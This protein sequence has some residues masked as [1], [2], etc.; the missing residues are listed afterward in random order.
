LADL[1]CT[2]ISVPWTFWGLFK[3]RFMTPK[4]RE[5]YINRIGWDSNYR[6]DLPTWPPNHWLEQ[7]H[8]RAAQAQENGTPATRS[9]IGTRV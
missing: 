8:Q 5:A 3:S 6:P 1:V 7:K 2:E 9:K 4:Q